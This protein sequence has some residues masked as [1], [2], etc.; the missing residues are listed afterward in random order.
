MV[1]KKHTMLFI[2]YIYQIFIFQQWNHTTLANT[3]TTTEADIVYNIT[4]EEWYR[5]CDA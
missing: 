5:L 4:E 1:D 2:M 3:P